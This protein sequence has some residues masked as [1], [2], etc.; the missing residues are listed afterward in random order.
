MNINISFQCS[1]DINHYYEIIKESI[2]TLEPSIYPIVEYTDGI[3]N[4]PSIYISIKNINVDKI[5]S[6]FNTLDINL[7]GVLK[8]VFVCESYNTAASIRD[9]IHQLYYDII[10]RVDIVEC[11]PY[12]A[13]PVSSYILHIVILQNTD[14]CIRWKDLFSYHKD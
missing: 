14:K 2:S 10:D 8:I 5:F 9:N 4:Y 1:S 6:I 12:C 11:P 7:K 3:G 13:K